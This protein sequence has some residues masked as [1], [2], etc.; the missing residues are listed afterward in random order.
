MEVIRNKAIVREREGVTPSQKQETHGVM[1]WVLSEKCLA[2]A[3]IL[4]NAT[5]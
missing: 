3:I 2:P 5:L 4:P 1:P